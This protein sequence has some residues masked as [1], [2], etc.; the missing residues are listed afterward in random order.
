MSNIADLCDAMIAA[1]TGVDLFLDGAEINEL[2][3]ELRS[4]GYRLVR[5][6]NGRFR[7]EALA[8]DIEDLPDP[9]EKLRA[10]FLLELDAEGLDPE[11]EQFFLLALSSLEQA[12]RFAKLAVYKVRQA[13]AREKGSWP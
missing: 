11:A 12:A 13:R 7:A 10:K 5:M 6:V 2:E 3:K 9:I 1:K 8:L 4:T